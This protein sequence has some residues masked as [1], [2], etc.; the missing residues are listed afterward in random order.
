M[1][2]AQDRAD[3]LLALMLLTPV[4]AWCARHPAAAAL[5]ALVAFTLLFPLLP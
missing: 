5:V 3:R 2:T 4:R 1:E